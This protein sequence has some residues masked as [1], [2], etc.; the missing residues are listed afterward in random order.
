MLIDQFMRMG[1]DESQSEGDLDLQKRIC[2]EVT[3]VIRAVAES[4]LWH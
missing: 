3:S 2:L 4:R 1:V